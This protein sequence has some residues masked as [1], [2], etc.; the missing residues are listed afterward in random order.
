MHL[1]HISIMSF[2]GAFPDFKM[3]RHWG[4][5]GGGGANLDSQWGL[6]IDPCTKWHFIWGDSRGAGLLTE[7]AEG[8][9]PP[10]LR[11]WYCS[12][13]WVSFGCLSCRH[14]STDMRMSLTCC[15][16]VKARI[17]RWG[18]STG[19]SQTLYTAPGNGVVSHGG[20]N[21][22]SSDFCHARKNKCK[23]NVFTIF[24]CCSAFLSSPSDRSRCRW[25][26]HL[27][28]NH[29]LFWLRGRPEDPKF[30]SYAGIKMV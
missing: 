30:E 22:E 23:T 10:W 20:S 8:P 17:G 11:L 19:R 27:M 18:L 12:S 6:S 13:L 25:H 28:T 14:L 5:K 9:Q 1:V 7:G 16:T 26:K 15:T 24:A 21:W 29:E 2:S 4:L 3:K